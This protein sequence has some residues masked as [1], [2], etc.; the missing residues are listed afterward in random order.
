MEWRDCSGSP[1]AQNTASTCKL[2]AQTLFLSG[3]KDCYTMD[4]LS[5]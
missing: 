4:H 1:A 3:L 5:A 2:R